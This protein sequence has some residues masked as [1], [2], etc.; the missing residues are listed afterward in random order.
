MEPF[1]CFKFQKGDSFSF[2]FSVQ[3]WRAVRMIVD[4]GLHYTGMKRDEA[5]KL[6][7]DKAWD[8]SDFTRKEVSDITVAEESNLPCTADKRYLST[9]TYKWQR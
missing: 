1:W 2:F 4:T 5:I 3:I 6:F 8:D 7:A 9:K